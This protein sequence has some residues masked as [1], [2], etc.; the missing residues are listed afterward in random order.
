[1][2]ATGDCVRVAA[3][4]DIHVGESGDLP[5]F[6][7]VD[8]AADLLLLA[9]DLTRT[10]TR[11]EVERLAGCLVEVQVPVVAV[12]GNHDHHCDTPELVVKILQ[13]IGV[14]VLEQSSCVLELGDHRVGVAGTKGFGGGMPGVSAT[15]FGE[16]EMKAFVR[17]GEQIASGLSHALAELDTDV[18]LVLLHYSPVLET[19]EGEPPEIHAF[20]G[21]YRLAEAVDEHGADLVLHGH[22]HMG[23]ERGRTP[24][25]VPVR[26][27]AKP[28]I[29][30]PY[31]VFELPVRARE[32]S[33]APPS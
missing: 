17:H 21:D 29:R 10:G 8:D 6:E 31:R 13:S 22:A 9:G 25:G 32:L 12:L 33:A 11:A 20:L 16:P 30:A 3:V 2:S 27:V 15:A 5:S 14:T 7:G 28:V 19:L 26:N 4:G 18:R 24:G 23:R 1:V